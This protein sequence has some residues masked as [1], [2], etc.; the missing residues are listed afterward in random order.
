MAIVR[1]N[2]PAENFAIDLGSLGALAA[3]AALAVQ[4]LMSFLT[5]AATIAAMVPLFSVLYLLIKRGL[6]GL[7]WAAFTDLPPAAMMD[8]GGFGN[9]IVGTLVIVAIATV[10]NVPL[11]ILGAVY[12]ADF[13]ADRKIAKAVQLA[14]K[15][16]DRPAIYS[17]GSVRI[18]D[19]RGSNRRI[20]RA[21]RWSGAGIADAADDHADG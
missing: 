9:A 2:V 6:A 15:C 8:G 3:P 21:S 12:I 5:G 13:G 4:L 1:E 18:R 7:N 14:A 20:F 19:C 17:G 10:I 11:G 16:A